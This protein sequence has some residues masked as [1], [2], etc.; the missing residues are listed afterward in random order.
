MNDEMKPA[1]NLRKW[2]KRLGYTQEEAA[3]RLG[4]TL[5]TVRNWENS[6]AGEAIPTWLP[7]LC[8]RLE[9][10]WKQKNE[11][12]GPVA[13]LYCD[14]PMTQPIW[15]PVRPPTM[16]REPWPTMKDAITRAV[17]LTG[18]EPYHS[19][20]IVDEDGTIWGSREL[21]EECRMLRGEYQKQNPR[22]GY[23][24]TVSRYH[25]RLAQALGLFRDKEVSQKEIRKAY[26]DAH[27]GH[28]DDLQWLIASDHCKN[29]TNKAPCE[30]SLTE[31]AL[32]E[33][34][35]RNRYRIR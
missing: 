8:D 12:Y 34:L 30:C 15:G 22:S 10:R 9:R 27:P 2:R 25:D 33:K 11:E 21:A 24:S 3:E 28:A 29:H 5:V 35:G 14:G 18:S 6:E 32:F 1:N 4:V 20:L 31:N 19:G 7:T 17:Q 13:L 26:A 16:H 23:S